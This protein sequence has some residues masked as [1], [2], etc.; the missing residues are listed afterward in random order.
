MRRDLAQ[1]LTKGLGSTVPR[2]YC[3]I[4][5]YIGYRIRNEGGGGIRLFQVSVIARGWVRLQT[6]AV[7]SPLSATTCAAKLEF[8]EGNLAYTV[9]NPLIYSIPFSRFFSTEGGRKHYGQRDLQNSNKEVYNGPT[10]MECL[11]SKLGNKKLY[12]ADG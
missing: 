7:V 2:I 11:W 1:S 8:S 12:L 6:G 5:K 10:F 4:L 9:Y 3:E